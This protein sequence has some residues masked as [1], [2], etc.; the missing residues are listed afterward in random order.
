[1]PRT[2]FIVFSLLLA[3][4]LSGCGPSL[5]EYFAGTQSYYSRVTAIDHAE[6]SI[7]PATIPEASKSTTYGKVAS[8]VNTA[9][10]VA[11]YA[12]TTDQKERLKNIVEPERLAH[13]IESSFN[14]SFSSQTQL[15][16]VSQS[17]TNPDFRILLSVSE[18]GLRAETIGSAM[19]FYLKSQIKVVHVA[20]MTTIYDNHIEIE[21]SASDYPQISSIINDLIG[22]AFNLGYFF[23]LSDED[24]ATIFEILCDDAGKLMAQKLVDDIYK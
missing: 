11:T 8:T 12:I 14:A 3:C 7:E 4:L 23:T 2:L 21:R 22:A 10:T 18:Y 1:M 9:S 20:S 24:V 19:F 5:K 15:E 13:R 16:A 6:V 17:T